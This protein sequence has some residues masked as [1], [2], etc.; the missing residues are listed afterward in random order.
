MNSPNGSSPNQHETKMS[1][2]SGRLSSLIQTMLQ[3]KGYQLF[4]SK[5]IEGECLYSQSGRVLQD[6]LGPRRS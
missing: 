2:F 1:R 4:L 5:L 3:G 6:Q